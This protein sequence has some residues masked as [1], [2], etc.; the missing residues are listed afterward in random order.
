MYCREVLL[1][2]RRFLIEMPGFFQ[3]WKMTRFSLKGFFKQGP[4]C[5]WK[6][7]F[8]KQSS[9]LRKRIF[10]GLDKKAKSLSETPFKPDRVSF[11]TPSFYRG[12]YTLQ[13]EK[14]TYIV[15]CFGINVL[16]NYISVTRK[17]F[18]GINFSLKLHITYLFVIQRITWKSV[19]GKK[20]NILENFISVTCNNVLGVHFA[21]ISGWSVGFRRGSG[22]PNQRKW[23]SRTF[24]EGVRNEFWNPPPYLRGC[25][26]YLQ[27]KGSPGPFST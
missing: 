18:S 24:G 5:L 1:S 14:T 26:W 22:K 8:C 2:L 10:I 23:A 9:P 7:A 25:V 27:A 6:W 19:L 12:L 11:C 16:K 21:I 3:E 15:F 13:P 17:T 4:F 20:K